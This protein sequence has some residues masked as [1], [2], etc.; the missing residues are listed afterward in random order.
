MLTVERLTAPASVMRTAGVPLVSALVVDTSAYWVMVLPPPNIRIFPVPALYTLL[1]DSELLVMP[2]RPVSVMAPLEVKMLLLF[3]VADS[4]PLV[5][6]VTAPPA[7][8]VVPL[9]VSC[10]LVPVADTDTGAPLCVSV[11]FILTESA[12]PELEDICSPFAP[13]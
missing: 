11:A 2:P 7:V 5:E 3:C 9:I 4:K 6:I 8:V 1:D 13:L 12:E 10:V